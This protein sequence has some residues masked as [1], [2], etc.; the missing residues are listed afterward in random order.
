VAVNRLWAIF[1]GKGLVETIENFGTQ[2]QPPSHPELLDWLAR[3]FIQSRWNVKALVKKIVLSSAYRQASALRPALRAILGR[4]TSDV[5]AISREALTECA[6]LPGPDQDELAAAVL[7]A[8]IRRPDG[9]ALPAAAEFAARLPRTA[10]GIC[11]ALSRI[12]HASLPAIKIPGILRRLPDGPEKNAL[13]AGWAASSI[14]AVAAA[15]SAAARPR[16]GTG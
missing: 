3:D 2:G 4:I 5:P 12:P 1:W 11:D 10:L 14:P 7:D 15:A 9:A 6:A 16:P 13:A 8:A